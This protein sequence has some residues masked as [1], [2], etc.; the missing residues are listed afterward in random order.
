MEE[1]LFEQMRLSGDKF[2]EHCRDTVFP[3]W[4]YGDVEW[5]H[6][7]KRQI[8]I[9]EN[10][11]R[12]ECKFQSECHKQEQIYIEVEWSWDGLWYESKMWEQADFLA[13]GDLDEVWLISM[14]DL[15]QELIEAEAT[16]RIRPNRY[17][18]SKGFTLPLSWV[19]AHARKTWR[20]EEA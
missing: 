9:G 7:R 4:G 3:S 20:R 18:T 8:A 17:G 16:G 14:D 10:S 13:T 1:Q 15:I 12:I 11:A 6:D 5:F 2:E 19:R